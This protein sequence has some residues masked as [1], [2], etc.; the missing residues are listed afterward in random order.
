M[1]RS[2]GEGG[3]LCHGEIGSAFG[4]CY[5][6]YARI[7]EEKW[8]DEFPYRRISS[9][10]GWHRMGGSFILSCTGIELFMQR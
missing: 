9:G 6:S 5:R 4:S 10:T 2:G 1:E 3:S 8:R 7:K